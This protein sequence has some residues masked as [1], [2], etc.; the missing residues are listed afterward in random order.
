[1]IGQC[2]TILVTVNLG[3]L[4]PEHVDVQV[5]HGL[6][7]NT[8]SIND[9]AVDNLRDIRRLSDGKYE[10]S[11]CINCTLSGM[12]GFSIRIIPRHDLLDN[13]YLPGMIRWAS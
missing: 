12:Q 9:G 3:D 10:F 4:K 11:G 5:Y 13:P 6:V 1:M 2:I 8:G 7:D